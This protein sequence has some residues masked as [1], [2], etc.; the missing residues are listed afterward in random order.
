[1]RSRLVL[2]TACSAFGLCTLTASLAGASD[3]A[4]LFRQA[5]ERNPEI[6]ASRAG[7]GAARAGIDEAEANLW[8]PTVTV[9]LGGDYNSEEERLSESSDVQIDTYDT[10]A[11]VSVDLP[12]Y[13]GGL[14]RARV[15]AAR[16]GLSE[17]E[18]TVEATA[19]K[20][21]DDIA[22]AYAN[23]ILNKMSAANRRSVL[24]DYHRLQERTDSMRER[25]LATV[26]EV[27]QVRANVA[28]A[29][30]ELDG[31]T[32]RLEVARAKLASLV[33]GPTADPYDYP[34]L[35]LPDSLEQALLQAREEN[36]AIRS[37]G[38]AA[39]VATA[40]IDAAEAGHLPS[41]SLTAAYEYS[42][43]HEDSSAIPGTER[44][45][46]HE[47]S[48]TLSVGIPLFNQGL[49]S[50][51]VRKARQTA[52]QRRDQVDDET[53][54]TERAV[55]EAWQNR[56]LAERTLATAAERIAQ[57]MEIYGHLEREFTRGQA[58]LVDLLDARE[59]TL[60]AESM[61]EQARHDLFTAE[62]ALLRATGRLTEAVLGARG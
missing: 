31:F 7:T 41:V 21:F 32:S 8:L 16:Y 50:A 25:N 30:V 33:G 4:D 24:E 11:T 62:I 53:A 15:R 12:L 45:S 48:L 19:H 38:Y 3:L 46:G 18:A 17:A 54:S 13:D 40:D 20:V 39:Q 42:Y 61:L 26:T 58:D 36:P 60:R 44:I 56:E 35:A 28:E 1:M 34:V 52:L 49:V 59:D 2:V 37:A 6:S 23:F 51:S 57:R 10:D 43:S 14:R 27:L 47:G 5:L 29:E 9:G 55:V 22:M